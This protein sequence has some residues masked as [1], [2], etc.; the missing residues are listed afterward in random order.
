LPP[1]SPQLRF[2]AL[3]ETRRPGK[4]ARVED[5]R[6]VQ[7]DRA[8]VLYRAALAHHAAGSLKLAKEKYKELLLLPICSSPVPVSWEP[9]LS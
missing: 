9:A 1:L 8:T 6:E 2:V 4:V 3:N 5:L 7:I